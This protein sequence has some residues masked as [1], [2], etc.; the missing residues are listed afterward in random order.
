MG[1]ALEC[2]RTSST[3]SN[4]RWT[5]PQRERAQEGLPKV[6]NSGRCAAAGDAGRSGVRKGARKKDKSVRLPLK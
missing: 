4:C 3:Q 1:A 5:G 6:A 2:C